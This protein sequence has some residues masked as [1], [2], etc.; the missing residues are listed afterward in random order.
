MFSKKWE[1]SKRKY[2]VVHEPE[3]AIPVSA[4]FT[5]DSDVFRPDSDEKFPVIL[6]VFPFYKEKQNQPVKPVAVCP[7]WVMA[8]GGDYNF[9]VRRGYVHV[10]ANLRG[11]GKSGGEFD[12]LGD[13]TIQDMYDMI[14]WLAKQPWCD[15]QVATFG[16]SYFAMPAKRV[17]ELKPPSLKTIFAPFGVTDQYRHAIYQGGIF[18]YVFHPHWLKSLSNLRVRK[19]YRKQVGQQEFDR[20]IEK[21]L[22]DPEINIHPELVDVLKNP[23]QGGNMLIV[24]YILNF[25]DTNYYKEK[26]MR[27]NVDVTI[28]GYFGGCWAMHSLHLPG[29]VLSFEHWKG[30]KKLSVGPPLYL[31]RPVYQYHY[32]SLRWFDYWL[33]G[34][35]TGIMD[36]PKVQLFIQNT[37]EWKTAHEWPLPETKWTEFYLHEDGLL[38]EH[39][40]LPHET[41]TSFRDSKQEHGS[42]QFIS[43][44]MVENTEICGPMVLNLYASTTDVE[45]LWFVNFFE[46]N[47]DGDQKVLTR[48]W[49]R[50]SQR[51]ID[52]AKSTP[53]RPYHPHDRRE[54]LTPGEVYE[55]NI[56][57]IPTG[58][59]IQAGCRFGITI[60]CADKDDKPADFLD[61]HGIGHLW[62][63]TKAEITIEHNNQY[64][65]HLLV[66]ITKGNRIGTFLSGG[67]LGPLP[68]H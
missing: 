20:Q 25:L 58:V 48:G 36:E 1:T 52:P 28:P 44:P 56:E 30:P 2:Q 32:E 51:R 9:Y 61:L 46:V 42:V 63:E 18:S 17:A 50:G 19:E 62:R 23:D 5:L 16:T 43:P 57:V 10:F 54:P 3:V 65:S 66:P 29:D 7:E 41:S 37:G 40:L 33:K 4:G 26:G 8:E 39:E 38:F 6:S 55:F 11:T 34:I 35:D 45:A 15:G 12:H 47:E 24:D 67:I 22:A 13:G 64:P 59:L 60:K 68:E 14:E 31:D 27:W 49:L 53:W 21:A